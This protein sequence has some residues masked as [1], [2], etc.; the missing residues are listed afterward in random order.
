MFVL[1]LGAVEGRAQVDSAYAISIGQFQGEPGDTVYMP[2]YLRN[3]GN[4]GGF[5]FRFYIDYEA[6]RPDLLIPLVDFIDTTLV[7]TTKYYLKTE[8]YGRAQTLWIHEDP[9]NP[10][11]SSL[12][13]FTYNVP[14]SDSL[15][16][17]MIISFIPPIIFDPNVQKPYIAPLASDSSII[18]RVPFLVNP[19]A[20]LG[21]YTRIVFRDDQFSYVENQLSDTLG[22]VFIHPI[23]WNNN[24]FAVGEDPCAG[25]DCPCGCDYDNDTCIVCDT[26][27]D[28]NTPVVNPLSQTSYDIEQG[29]T[30][31]FNVSASDP[32]AGDE[33][34]LE[35]VGLPANATF[36]PSNPI[37]GTDV[38][39]T[40][41]FNWTPSFGQEGLFS[42][43]FRATDEHSASNSRSV[44]INVSKIDK[45]RLYTTSTY[46]DD[47][48]GGLPG[49]GEIAFPIDL[50]S[51]KTVYG[52]QFDMT[53]PA[54]VAFLDSITVTDRTPDY[55]IYDNVGQYPDSV[56]IVAFGLN[57]EPIVD[58]SSTAILQAWFTLDTGVVAADY[59]VRFFDAWESIDPDPEVPSE[60][61]EVDSG[62]IQVD[63]VGDV[64]L[65]R[66]I[67][68][69]DLVNVVG[70]IIGNFDL[71]TRNYATANVVV[72]G[73]V[74]VIDLIG[75]VNLIF[76]YPVDATPAPIYGEGEVA[77]MKIV[78][79]DLYAGQL[80]KLNVRGEFPD[81][82]AGVQMQID[83]DP[84]TVTLDKPEIPDDVNNFSMAYKDDGGGRMTIVLYS[85][86]PWSN[87]SRIRS[88]AADVIHLPADIK[89]DIRAGDD[90]KIRIT[91]AYL[92]NG[93]AHEIPMEQN[94]P[95]L[96]TTFSLRQNYP[97]PF[98]PITKIEF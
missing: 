9:G 65:D 69:A 51:T 86:E 14:I 91:R 50:A 20:Q 77:S 32:D 47:P 45:D 89:R 59:W 42:I 53:Y 35:A 36:S 90:S 28:N 64:N 6:T 3:E 43:T 15:S 85:R 78:H 25:L 10:F 84:E 30:V 67:D 34:C 23:L 18:L 8:T 52:I 94:V 73:M 5:L 7:D 27:G 49:A 41:T 44:T 63:F 21:D 19:D 70:Y 75:I 40:G 96:P 16:D 61:L 93:D 83:Y 82:V 79:D 22:S 92:S 72:D 39:V 48:V 13:L 66:H 33:V 12:N 95:I 1:A 68:V 74:N 24:F 62:I 57:N 55:V 54:A 38:T 11:D 60:F 81:E 80:T 71:V 58:G 88:G 98:N 17:T 31:S 97:N 56:R 87:E 26:T 37:C 76:G 46:G 29:Q 2:I 4:V